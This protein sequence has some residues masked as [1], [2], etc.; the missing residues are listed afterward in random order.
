MSE[1]IIEKIENHFEQTAK[2][3]RLLIDFFELNKIPP[4][5]GASTMCRILGCMC[6][7]SKIG[8]EASS[9]AFFALIVNYMEILDDR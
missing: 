2:T 7:D 5:L 3:S 6:L 4:H 1:E 8:K 9:K